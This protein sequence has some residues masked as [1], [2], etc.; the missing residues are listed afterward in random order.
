MFK[1]GRLGLTRTRGRNYAYGNYDSNDAE[2]Y[3][4][5]PENDAL[6]DAAPIRFSGGD[7]SFIHKSVWEYHPSFPRP[8][9]L[10]WFV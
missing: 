7:Y 3:F 4:F 9:R 1:Q 6:Q 10:K 8:A 5:D 2:A